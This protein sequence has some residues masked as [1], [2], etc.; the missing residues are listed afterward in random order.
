MRGHVAC[1]LSVPMSIDALEPRVLF[2]AVPV[3]DDGDPNDQ[4]SEAE[5]LGTL[6]EASD[7]TG[8]IDPETDVDL[9][10]FTVAAGQ[11]VT[12]DLDAEDSLLDSYLR[13]F[14]ADGVQ[15]ASNDDGAAPGEEDTYESFLEYTFTTA[16]TY[17]LGISG[18]GN[19]SYDAST[20]SGDS[21]GSTGGYALTVTPTAAATDD[22][23]EDND[24]LATA[25][26]LGFRTAPRTYRGLKLIDA[27]DYFRFRTGAR[28]TAD[29]SVKILFNHA[30]GDL[31]L[32]LYNARGQLV[33]RSNGVSNSEEVSLADQPAGL[34]FVR[35]LGYEAATNTYNLVIDPTGAAP[36]PVTDDAYENND[37]RAAA[38]G[39]GT[40][41]GVRAINNLRM[42]DGHDWFRFTMTGPGTADDFARIDFSH[43]RGDLDLELYDR[44]GRLVQ[45]SVSLE[46]FER[47][48]LQRL[49]AG[50]YFLHVLGYDGAQNP[51]YSLTIDP[52]VGTAPPV[53]ADD[54]R[55]NNDTLGTAN[56]LGT[57]TS[58]LTV[59]DLVM[60]DAADFFRFN[61]ASTGDANSIVRITFAH[62]RGDLDLALYDSA[63]QL[64]RSS[65]G[66]AG[67]EQVS[68]LGLAPG[69]YT[70]KVYGYRAA[71]NPDYTLAITP[72]AQGNTPPPP[73]GRNV[74]YVNFDGINLTNNQLR[75]WAGNDW[76]SS[77]GDYLDPEG[78]G[79]RVDRFFATRGDRNQII[80][81]IMAR[82]QAD[83]RQFGVTVR[84]IYSGAVQ[85]QGAT[86]LFFGTHNMRD[87]PHVASDVD[88]GNDNRTD[89]AF[90]KDEDWTTTA[91][92]ITAL[93]DVALH[94][95][96]HTF[97]L[98]HVNILQ[99]GTIFNESMGLR[100]SVD[101][102]HWLRDTA[103]L[104][105]NF[106]EYL[107]HGGGR[108]SQ[109]AYLTMRRNFGLTTGLIAANKVDV[110]YKVTRNVLLGCFSHELGEDAHD[111]EHEEDR[112]DVLAEVP[113]VA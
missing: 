64:I 86:T 31:D 80:S 22:A 84:R 67:S 30:A 76:Q 50:E 12:F 74:L 27:G 89:I 109:N 108:G 97:G 107:N 26:N 40:L 105:R 62:D 95:A 47:I 1:S 91:Q 90:I 103:F 20:G 82:L 88:Y 9:L 37:T 48:S 77:V 112:V 66:T 69:Q 98:F 68:L 87:V 2:S 18:Y 55:E 24:T 81:G 75:T 39:L 17:Y 28:G 43:A 41:G 73:A 99:N 5:D 42:L 102:S 53:G 32:E 10:R 94:E 3:A 51:G 54:N 85:N 92:A 25:A 7:F 70:I 78:D 63:G 101:Q 57:V 14:D 4:L 11:K 59:N 60:A 34:Y 71:R 46:D 21:D 36:P 13:L 79:I 44:N 16:G 49:P 61:L 29:D 6:G 8:S 113:T 15:I 93:S 72:P 110:P 35:V 38:R 23:F 45:K 58:P 56:N 33:G 100:Y 19:T 111:H 104:N 96:G 65:A 83:L 52:A 106:P